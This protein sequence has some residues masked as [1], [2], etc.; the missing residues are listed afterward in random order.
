MEEAADVLDLIRR[1]NEMCLHTKTAFEIL[2]EEQINNPILTMSQNIDKILDGGI[3]L[4]KVTEVA[5]I[6]GVG[7][8]QIW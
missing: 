4:S 7:K 5:G 3:H 1:P 8:T 2:K 6:A